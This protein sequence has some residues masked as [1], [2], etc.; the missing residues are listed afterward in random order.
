[1][2]AALRRRARSRHRSHPDLRVEGGDLPARAD[3]RRPRRRPASR[4]HDG[5]GL[6][7]ARPGSRLRRSRCPPASA[8]R[9]ERLP[10][11]SR[12]GRRRDLGPS[13]HR[14]DQLS[15]QSDRSDRAARLSR[16]TRRSLGQARVPARIG[17]GLHGALVRRSA[18]LRARGARPWERRGLQ[19]AEQALVDDR[20]PLWLRRRRR[21]PDCC[22][23][24]VQALGRH[25]TA[26]VRAA[27]VDR[28]VGRRGTRR[29]YAGRLSAKARR[30]APDTPAQGHP[31]RRQRG[32]DVPLARGTAG[33]DRP[34]RSRPGCSSTG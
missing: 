8:A 7:G 34:R 1:M 17:R 6:P 24:T 26:G 20:I 16:A 32:D 25:R 12:R 14:L 2:R 11:R 28:G 27:C 21:R 19:H 31:C 22:A 15:E 13:G 4:R 18:P 9:G 33:S 3:A 5:A 23:E 10:A 29:A 30:P